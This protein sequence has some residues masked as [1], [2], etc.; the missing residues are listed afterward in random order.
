MRFLGLAF[1][2]VFFVSACGGDPSTRAAARPVC[3]I[4]NSTHLK[5]SVFDVGTDRR[6]CDGEA[7][8]RLGDMIEVLSPTSD[9]GDFSECCTYHGYL[10]GGTGTAT[11]TV[12][13]EGYE[14]F[15][16]E[17]VAI[18]TSEQCDAPPPSPYV[19]DVYLKPVIAR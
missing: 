18:Q 8:A 17:N 4:N 16:I 12:S 2:S 6:V 13:R 15:V 14:D 5:I 1:I 11:I 7:I 10:A 9:C 3:R 19:A